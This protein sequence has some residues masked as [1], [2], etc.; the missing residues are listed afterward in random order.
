M[1]LWWWGLLLKFLNALSIQFKYIGCKA[2]D[3]RKT[4]CI[5]KRQN[6]SNKASYSKR[7]FSKV[8]HSLAYI[9]FFFLNMTGK[10]LYSNIVFRLGLLLQFLNFCLIP[11]KI[12]SATLFGV[13]SSI[14]QKSLNSR[15]KTY[16]RFTWKLF[17]WINFCKLLA[18]FPVYVSNGLP[19]V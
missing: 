12:F 10:F 9:V 4:L 3:T 5:D 11:W 7:Y 17:S 15:F 2:V 18:Y 1:R 14:I 19:V 13:S 8:V 6:G 16:N